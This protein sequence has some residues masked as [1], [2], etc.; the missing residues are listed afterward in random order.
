MINYLFFLIFH[1]LGDFN[2][3]NEKLVKSKE[4][5][6]K[7]LF[8]HSGIYCLFLACPILFF[9]D[10]LWGCFLILTMFLSHFFIDFMKIRLNNKIKTEKFEYFSFIIDQLL[11]IILIIII[12]AIISN[13]FSNYIIDTIEQFNIFML[14]LNLNITFDNLIVVLFP[15][16]LVITPS[17]VFI[18]KTFE[19]VFKNTNPNINIS[20]PEKEYHI[21]QNE[22]NVGSLIGIIERLI[23]VILGLMGL[24]SSIVIV[25]TAKSIARF[26]TIN[27]DPK[28]AEKYLVGTLLSLLLALIGLFLGKI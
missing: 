12:V 21:D 7:F 15:I 16:V 25:L 9:C 19:Y 1:F 4:E 28:F 11:H 26:K 8:I 3:Q 23:I 6:L 13:N 24:Y 14:S 5:K 10:L 2:F 27:D 20:N 18:K 22:S 17:K